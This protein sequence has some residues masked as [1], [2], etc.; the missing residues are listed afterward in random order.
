MVFTLGFGLAKAPAIFVMT[1]QRFHAHRLAALSSLMVV[2]MLFMTV[3][4]YV[5]E[6]VPLA[7]VVCVFVSCFFQS[8]IYG[9]MFSY[10][11]GR[12]ATEALV[13]IATGFYSF[14]GPLSR[15][16]ARYVV[17]TG[18]VPQNMMPLAIGL[19]CCPVA[20][21]LLALVDSSPASRPS[22]EDTQMRAKRMP[23]GAAEQWK[24]LWDNGFG[25]V[26]LILSVTLLTGLRSFR[27]FFSQD[28]F[29]AALGLESPPPPIFF[30]LVDVPGS[31]MS[32]LVIFSF[33]AVKDS[34]RALLSM[35]G[36]GFC[37]VAL[38]ATTNALFQAT[39]ISGKA[40]CVLVGFFLYT[41]Y[42][43]MAGPVYDRLVAATKFNGTC[44]FLIFM[45]DGSGYAGTILLLLYQTFSQKDGVGA[46]QVLN[47]FLVLIY[48]CTALMLGLLLLG[49]VFYTRKLPATEEAIEDEQLLQGGSK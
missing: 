19:V 6:K 9:G 7:Q 11:E 23:V 1:G 4:V 24:F 20:V 32:C 38:L 29:T 41:A 42:G 12:K 15:A 14:A 31:I 48:V 39:A 18:V 34:R 47:V 21:L 17:E 5:F 28:I 27:D 37:S 43:L 33:K 30:F 46:Q 26:C 22:L 8:W 36:V 10:L 49:A 45:S 44:T 40:W 3:S 2:S 25:L 13:A 35:M 16:T